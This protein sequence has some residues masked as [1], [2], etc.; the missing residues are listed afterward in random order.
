MTKRKKT[1]PPK[2]LDG[3]NLLNRTLASQ[4]RHKRLSNSLSTGKSPRFSDVAF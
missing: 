3:G 2:K 4:G 1:A